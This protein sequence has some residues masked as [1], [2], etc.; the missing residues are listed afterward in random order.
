MKYCKY[1]IQRKAYNR[2]MPCLLQYLPCLNEV[3]KLNKQTKED[4]RKE[5]QEH[6]KTAHYYSRQ[7]KIESRASQQSL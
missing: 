1:H 7:R 3:D 6:F 4:I 5:S 2:Y